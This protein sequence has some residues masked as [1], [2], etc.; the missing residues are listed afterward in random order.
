[1]IKFNNYPPEQAGDVELTP[2]ALAKLKSIGRALGSPHIDT[3]S[4]EVLR[5]TVFAYGESIGRTVV[6]SLEVPRKR[7]ADSIMEPLHDELGDYPS[8]AE[9]FK[10]GDFYGRS[11]EL[12]RQQERYRAATD[13]T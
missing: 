1:M 4:Q 2:S 11:T 3:H 6:A 8:L 12:T 9:S 7:T 13:I 5:N 10:N